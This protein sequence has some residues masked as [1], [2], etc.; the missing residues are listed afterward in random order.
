MYCINC[1]TKWLASWKKRGWKTQGKKDVKN[2]EIIQRLERACNKHLVKWKHV[3]GHS[4]DKYND[5]ADELACKA[6]ALL[7]EQE[8]N[9]IG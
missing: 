6:S 8:E 2:K 7:K 5:L 3:K 1:M 9:E 4:G